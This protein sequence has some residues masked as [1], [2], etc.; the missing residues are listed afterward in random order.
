MS[1]NWGLKDKITVVD[2]TSALAAGVREALAGEGAS[3]ADKA[4]A[5]TEVYV[6]VPETLHAREAT[7]IDIGADAW[8][9][10]MTRLF[11]APR[12]ATH[13][14]LSGMMDR[15]AG[16]IVH[17]IGS[18]EPKIFNAEFAA[19]GAMAAWSKSLTRAIGKSGPTMN[20]IQ[21]GIMAD[22]DASNDDRLEKIPAGR[23]CKPEDISNLVVFL[24][25]PYARYLT[26]TVIP[27]DGGF[28]RYQN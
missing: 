25:S 10:E 14:V 22:G 2:G 9:D 12:K 26:G 11:E 24:C 16:R 17:V 27:V 28:R 3:I 15:G 20:L 19:W 7:P 8:G 23:F 1:R 18:F 6:S 4:D 13:D 21:A 5:S